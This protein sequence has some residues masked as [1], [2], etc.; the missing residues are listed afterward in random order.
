MLNIAHPSDAIPYLDMMIKTIQGKHNLILPDG[1][2][3]QFNITAVAPFDESSGGVIRALTNEYAAYNPYSLDPGMK[4]L[5][6]DIGGKIS[7]MTPAVLM[8]GNEVYPL[9]GD[10]VTFELGIQDIE[11]NLQEELRAHYPDTFRRVISQ[12]IINQIIVGG[13]RAVISG[14]PMDF[15][16]VFWLAA[17]PL[18]SQIENIYINKMKRAQDVVHFFGTGGGS[19]RL[20]HTLKTDIFE[21]RSF[22][23]ADNSKSI[24][25]ANARG[26]FYALRQYVEAHRENGLRR[27]FQRPVQPVFATIDA[28]NSQGKGIS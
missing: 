20:E 18:L 6:V 16:E 2:K 19:G 24:H 5:T 10:G 3:I 12:N 22:S 14:E 1:E 28:G 21:G 23:L 27:L 7:S 17:N 13:G 11:E 9:F 26:G 25:L 15:T 4:I 8:P